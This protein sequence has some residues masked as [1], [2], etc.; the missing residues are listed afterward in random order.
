MGRWAGAMNEPS[1]TSAKNPWDLP[2]PTPGHCQQFSVVVEKESARELRGVSC[3]ALEEAA[4]AHNRRDPLLAA[5]NT[6]A[7]YRLKKHQSLYPATS[8]QVAATY[9]R[10]ACEKFERCARLPA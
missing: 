6:F 4:P 3:L 2:R 5:D 1:P 7:H 8:Y 10:R 9:Y